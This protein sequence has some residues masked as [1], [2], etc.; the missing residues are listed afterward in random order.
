MLRISIA[1]MLITVSVPASAQFF[2]EVA[3]T[4]KYGVGCDEK[5]KSL[6]SRLGM[7]SVNGTTFRIWCPNGRVFERDGEQ[8]HL[9]VVRSICNLNQKL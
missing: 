6:D 9:G 5:V 1:V 2:R 7:C 8:P 3:K 4:V